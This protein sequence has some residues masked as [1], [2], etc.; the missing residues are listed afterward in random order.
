[1][2]PRYPAGRTYVVTG[3]SVAEW[4]R[5][6]ARAVW[7]AV[8]PLRSAMQRYGIDLRNSPSTDERTGRNGLHPG[9]LLRDRLTMSLHMIAPYRRRRLPWLQDDRTPLPAVGGS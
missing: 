1:V 3:Y 5:N 6:G 2:R 9:Q 8:T 7:S 4:P